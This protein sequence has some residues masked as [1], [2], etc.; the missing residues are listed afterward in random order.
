MNNICSEMWILGGNMAAVDDL[1]SSGLFN[2]LPNPWN[3]EELTKVVNDVLNEEV[4]W[5][6][7][8]LS[9]PPEV[10]DHKIVLRP[11]GVRVWI[12]K[13]TSFNL[14]LHHIYQFGFAGISEEQQRIILRKIDLLT[15]NKTPDIIM[16]CKEADSASEAIINSIVDSLLNQRKSVQST[17]E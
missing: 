11:I 1:G 4:Y 6:D 14:T 9:Y 5:R 3:K 17:A 16:A 12:I 15:T 7:L 2:L 13:E 10:L 8:I